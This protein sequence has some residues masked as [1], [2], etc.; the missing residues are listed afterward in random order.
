MQIY[1]NNFIKYILTLSLHKEEIISKANKLIWPDDDYS[2]INFY[3]LCFCIRV[4]KLII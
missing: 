2:I 3:V 4:L 1:F